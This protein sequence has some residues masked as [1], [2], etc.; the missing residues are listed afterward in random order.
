MTVRQHLYSTL[1]KIEAAKLDSVITDFIYTS[2]F[3][4]VRSSA[5]QKMEILLHVSLHSLQV[6]S[7]V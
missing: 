1:Y 2:R 5:S 3:I 6:N 7:K 4:T